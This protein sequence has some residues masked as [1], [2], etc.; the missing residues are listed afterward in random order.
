MSTR[1][2]FSVDQL[3]RPQ[4]GGIGTYVR[5]LALGLASLADPALHVSGLAPRS[6][7]PGEVT[8]LPL[9]LV[10]AALPLGVLTRV[11]P[12]WAVGVP[13]DAEIVHATS[14]AGPFGGGARAAVHS[15]AM[16]DLL[17]RDEPSAST[18]SGISFHEQRLALITRRSDLRVFTSSPAL[19]GRLVE[20]GIDEARIYRVR[21]GVDDDLVEAHSPDEVAR[22]LAG[23]GVAGPFTLYAGTREP[24]KNLERLI[25]AHRI[26]R[27]LDADLGPLVLCG[28]SGWG[29]V[30]TGDAV[31]LGLVGRTALKGLVRDATVV[32]YVAR[33]EG[34]GLPP[35]EALHAGTRVVVSLSTP[36]VADN[37]EVVPVDPLDVEDIARGLVQS[38][39]LANDAPAR[40]R[41]RASVAHLTWRN[42][43][44][45]HL[46]GWR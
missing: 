10:T 42:A 2:T 38:L 44:L 6:R 39:S 12:H 7:V 9:D 34:W 43:A 26:A 41:R 11:W 31:T 36:S 21:L 24:R 17:W 35:V 20:L 33:A 5:G 1:I 25:A 13:R 18:S 27:A 46:E 32:A 14:M 16:H 8:A 45:D 4:P 29:E 28:P 15:V 19:K 40:A 23:A 37:P 22:L 3:Y 30:P